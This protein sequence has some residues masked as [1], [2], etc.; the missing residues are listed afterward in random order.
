MKQRSAY[1]KMFSSFH[2][3]LYHLPFM[4][5]ILFIGSGCSSN[6]VD[7]DAL[8]ESMAITFSQPDFWLEPKSSFYWHSDVVFFYNDNR[9]NPEATRLFLQQE[10]QSYLATR[11]CQFPDNR[12]L[13]Q[14]SLVA[15]VVLGKSVT[16]T[17]IL[18][19]FKLTPSFQ[20]SS[21]FEKGTIVIAILDA[22][23]EK[24]LWRGALQANID[25]SL[26]PA[27]RQQRVREG[28]SRLLR[29]VPSQ[30]PNV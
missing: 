6:A 15:V 17:D 1:R 8:S 2:K 25:L 29:H 9:K 27:V 7:S 22:M 13:A 16:A 20:T 18:K 24:I 14:Y 5:A 12:N 19:Q 23:T 11:T 28:I 10:I 30:K 21:R 26:S 4:L 3:A